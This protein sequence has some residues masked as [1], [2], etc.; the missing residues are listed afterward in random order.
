MNPREALSGWVLL[1]QA[2]VLGSLRRNL[3]RAALSVL[4]IAFGVA[5]GVAVT[6]IN[7]AAVNEFSQAVRSLSGEADLVLRGPRAG[8]PESLYPQL[9]RDPQVALASPAVEVEAT[10]PGRDA[11]LKLVG[12]DPFRALR[13]QPMLLAPAGMDED[14]LLAPDVV[15]LSQEAARWLHVRPGDRLVI[16]VGLRARTLRVGGLLPA[17]GPRQRLG[18]MDIAGAQ[19]FLGRVGRLDRVDLRLR[20]GVDPAAFQARWQSRLP[21]GLTLAPPQAAGQRAENLSRAYRVNLTVLSLVA[22]FTGAFLVFST[23]A[24][25]VLR[26]RAQLALLRV[27]GVT[28]RG[29]VLLLLGEGLLIGLVGAALGLALGVGLAAAGLQL[30]GG[31]LGGGYFQGVRPQLQPDAGTLFIFFAL[32]VGVA[33]LGALAPA[34]EMARTAPA[35]ALRGGDVERALGRLHRAWP[36]LLLLGLGL[37]ATRAPPVR[38]LPLFGYLAIAL[39]LVGVVL[40]MP[41]LLGGITRRLPL[42]VAAPAQIAVAQLRGAPGQAA[43]AVAAIV[44]SFSLMVSMAIMVASFRQS[45]DDWL[46]QVL[47]AD[48][49]LRANQTL[50]SAFFAPADQAV[51]RA[52]PG[53]REVQ[54]LRAQDLL[55]APDK[56]AVALL[57]RD[58][59]PARIGAHLPLLDG[60]LAP[61]AGGPP[62]VWISEAVQDL[63]GYRPGQIVHLPIAGRQHAFFVAGVWRDYARQ[64]GAIVLERPLYRRLSGDDGASDAAIWLTPGATPQGV[65]AA[66]RARLPLGRQVE[67]RVPTEIRQISLAIFDR[68]FAVTYVL[69]VVAILI[70]LFGISN[71]FSAQ[72]LARRGEFGML[73]HLGM[74]R[75]QIGAMLATEAGIVG[76]LGVGVGLLLGWV[77]SLI[78]IFVVN[79]QSFHWSMDLHLPGPLLAGLAGLLVLAATLTAVGSA[80]QVMGRDIVRAVRE[81]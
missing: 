70:G 65:I 69:E 81:E 49:Y 44:V 18:V 72:V 55:L 50:G 67:M 8:F 13:L 51:I 73:R 56:P 58:L 26:R 78:L 52:T 3:G 46:G 79:R 75:R 14:D 24:M 31:D 7:G 80:R 35:P 63:Y 38:D 54:F 62:P 29:L 5:L 45:V 21:A 25:A 2:A 9:A 23:L 4:G 33:L 1:W 6:L 39:M 30:L 34:L 47:P 64:W 17:A 53:V 74:D 77:I 12:L 16:Q 59:D 40:L 27:L 20:P 48:L 68:S 60:P 19:W 37:L 28:P 66:L 11:T 76:A 41:T 22:L 10:L 57:A 43:V 15:F 61:P 42:P 36:G 71:S 32:G